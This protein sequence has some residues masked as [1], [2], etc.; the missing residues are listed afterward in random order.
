MPNWI[1]LTESDLNDATAAPIIL[2]AASS[3][4]AAGQPDPLPNLIAATVEELRGVIG[5]SGKYQLDGTSDA[6]I[7]SNLKKMAVEK[8]CREARKRLRLQQQPADIEDEKTYQARL[9]AIRDGKWPIE[10]PTI[11]ASVNPDL[12]TGR[13]ENIPGPTRE[14]RRSDLRNL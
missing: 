13:V 6:T 10:R 4:L 5:F 8:V 14:Y 11:A 1:L 12:P 2:A 9:N 3:V 7:P